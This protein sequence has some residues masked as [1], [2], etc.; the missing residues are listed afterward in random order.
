MNDPVNTINPNQLHL[1]TIDAVDLSLEVAGLG[2]RSYAFL[3]DWHIRVIFVMAWLAICAIA[4]PLFLDISLRDLLSSFNEITGAGGTSL[5]ILPVI[6]IY[7]LYHPVLEIIG[8]GRTPGKRMAGLRIVNEQ[9]RPPA[10]GAL[11]VRN[12]FRLV[13]GLPLFYIVGIMTCL[14][15]ERQRRLGDMAAG[16]LLVYDKSA[17]KIS[18]FSLAARSGKF[19]L[20][21]HELAGELVQ[22]WSELASPIRCR[23][24]RDFLVKIGQPAPE[25]DDDALLLKRIRVF[26]DNP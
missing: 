19:T 6:V 23:L 25:L 14:I 1:E 21:Q 3:I 12:I 20:A 5:V 22:R 26:L 24:A 13:D 17:A 16:T 2:A 7:F 11:L 15:S 8:R 10:M 4:F 9:G 18:A